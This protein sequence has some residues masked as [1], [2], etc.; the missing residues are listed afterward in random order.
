MDQVQQGMLTGNLAADAAKSGGN[1]ARLA[2]PPAADKPPDHRG[3]IERS[4]TAAITQTLVDS[5]QEH[6]RVPRGRP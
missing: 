1:G 5:G 6:D 4:R 3:L 2:R